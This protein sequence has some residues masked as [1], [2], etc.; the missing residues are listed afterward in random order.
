MTRKE[1]E[2]AAVAAHTDGTDWTAFWDR[3]RHAIALC[4]PFDRGRFHRLVRRLSH[5][6]SCGDLDGHRPAGDPEPWELDDEGA[7]PVVS[8]SETAAR[9]NWGEITPVNTERPTA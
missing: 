1:L 8:D 4:E 2:A 9:I 7:Y 3:Y 5:L 6:V